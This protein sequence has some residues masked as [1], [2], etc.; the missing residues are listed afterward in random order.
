[1]AVAALLDQERDPGRRRR[2]TR[3]EIVPSGGLLPYVPVALALVVVS[4]T[5]AAGRSPSAVERVATLV[6]IALLLARQYLAL[7]QNSALARRVAA[8]EEELE[9][10]AHHDALTGLANRAKFRERLEHALVL[11]ARD[12]RPVGLV[13]LDLDDF[14]LVNDALGHAAGDEL[15]VGVAGRIAGLAR[16]DDT[17]ARLG[18]DEF[19]VLLE[20]GDDAERFAGRIAEALRTP[21]RIAGRELTAKASAGAV[22][23]GEPDGPVGA[24]ELLARADHGMYTRKHAGK[25]LARTGSRRPAS[26]DRP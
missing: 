6:L 17:A 14:K 3:Q 26:L 5:E 24:D 9:Y 1:M 8:R 2:S 11:H 15:L 4:G 21:F 7:R 10:R 16:A 13:F 22:Q 20:S 19:A 23:L 12:R 25:H 18:G